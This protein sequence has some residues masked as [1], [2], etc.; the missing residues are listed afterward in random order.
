MPSKDDKRK[1]KKK[2]K[3]DKK[4]KLEAQIAEERLRKKQ[5]KEKMKEGETPEERRARRMAKK[6]KKD[7]K[8]EAANSLFGYS[9]EENP[10]GDGNLTKMFVWKK[11]F[12]KEI[13][14][15]QDP[16]KLTKENLRR[17]QEE[18]QREAGIP[19]LDDSYL[20]VMPEW[21][22][23]IQQLEEIRDADAPVEPA[24]GEPVY[25]PQAQV[26]TES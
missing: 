1:K 22:S 18:L 3:R 11:K 16:R 12:E 15:G 4:R 25:G 17:R 8:R 26:A 13:E 9:N 7:A 10:F 2:K 21:E 6:L 5:L 14:A 23:Q 19:F 24:E 20:P